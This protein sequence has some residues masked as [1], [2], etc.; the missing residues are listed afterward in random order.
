MI[1][2]HTMIETKSDMGSTFQY[3]RLTAKEIR[4]ATSTNQY[5]GRVVVNL[6]ISNRN[7]SETAAIIRRGRG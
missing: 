1:S 5:Q 4:Q 6:E 2:H 7:D 3:V